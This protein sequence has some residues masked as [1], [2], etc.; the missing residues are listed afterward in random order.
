MGP[1]WP[2]P[3]HRC[4]PHRLLWPTQL[5]A[6][7]SITRGSPA[8]QDGRKRLRVGC[9]PCPR[10]LCLGNT[11]V[12]HPGGSRTQRSWPLPLGVQR[13][14]PPPTSTAGTT[15]AHRH[16][17]RGERG[18]T[19]NLVFHL[20]FQQLQV[21]RATRGTGCGAPLTWDA[22]GLTRGLPAAGGQPRAFLRTAQPSPPVEGPRALLPPA[23]PWALGP[24]SP[25]AA[26]SLSRLGDPR[27][28]R[29]Q[30]RGC[31]QPSGRL[32]GHGKPEGAKAQARAGLPESPLAP[33]LLA[34]PAPTS[35]SP[36]GPGGS[37]LWR[38][39]KRNLQ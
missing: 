32:S 36:L 33:G 31:C 37:Q 28:P 2:V 24:T 38:V 13:C 11:P 17:C 18:F 10:Q 14:A 7:L 29:V 9:K 4:C 25:G 6:S 3:G 39:Q 34:T 23:S 12:P 35:S 21:S 20:L 8:P 16:S 22:A 15:G 19:R 5:L 26:R 1:S 30:G 27:Q